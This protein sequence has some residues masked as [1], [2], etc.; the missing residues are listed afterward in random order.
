MIAFLKSIREGWGELCPV[1][2]D[3][4]VFPSKIDQR[5]LGLY[6][7]AWANKDQRRFVVDKKINIPDLL[8]QNELEK[9]SVMDK[10]IF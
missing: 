8:A 10:I 4:S 2:I 6:Y 5:Q 3:V 9:S 1:E 7:L